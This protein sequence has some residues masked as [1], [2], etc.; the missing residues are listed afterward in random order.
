M[1]RG[2]LLPKM[3]II[4]PCLTSVK[5]YYIITHGY[6]KKNN[7]LY[8]KLNTVINILVRYFY[9]WWAPQFESSLP[10][11]VKLFL[12]LQGTSRQTDPILGWLG[13]AQFQQHSKSSKDLSRTTHPPPKIWIPAV[14]EC[15][16]YK[17]IAVIR[18]GYC[19]VSPIPGNLFHWERQEQWASGN[20]NIF[21]F[22]FS[23][24]LLGNIPIPSLSLSLNPDTSR[25]TALWR[26]TT[27]F[28]RAIRNSQ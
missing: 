27:V 3:N 15:V 26:L 12:H 7:S 1:P 23:P 24:S 20:T 19:V 2:L 5:S 10:H 9:L 6:L 16:I 21:R 11:M 14:E 25:P 22:L 18:P 17:C 28:W 4:F 8:L 13:S